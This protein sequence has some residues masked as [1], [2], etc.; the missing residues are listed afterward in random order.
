MA[1]RF[2]EAEAE[3][4]LAA[5]HRCCCVCHLF[6]GVK[7][8]LDHMKPGYESGDDSID[9]A[10]PVCFE[11]H[12]E[13]HMY[14]PLHPRGRRFR[15]AELRL[16]KAQWLAICAKQT[17]GR[18][19]RPVPRASVGPI[20]ALVDELDF[21]LAVASLASPTKRTTR[22]TARSTSASFRGRLGGA[23]SRSS[24]TSSRTPSSWPTRPLVQRISSIVA[25]LKT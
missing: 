20:Q 23:P 6:C 19:S 12:A 4:L 8:E 17:P 22:C 3:A 9:N 13:I 24:G 1:G 7:I 15:E 25:S 5:C 10:I 18:A 16:H 2:N 11:C 21:N 14:N